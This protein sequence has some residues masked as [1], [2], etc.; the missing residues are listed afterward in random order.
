MTD[1]TDVN[2]LQ[3]IRCSAATCKGQLGLT[4]LQTD[5]LEMG[6]CDVENNNHLAL[7]NVKKD[8]YY[9]VQIIDKSNRQSDVSV[10]FCGS[11]YIGIDDATKCTEKF[12]TIDKDGDG[13]NFY[14]DCNDEDPNINY[15]QAEIP[16]NDIDENCDGIAKYACHKL[17]DFDDDFASLTTTKVI[18]SKSD[19]T[20]KNTRWGADKIS[21]SCDGG[22]LLFQSYVTVQKIKIVKGGSFYFKMKLNDPSE[23][24]VFALYKSS[25]NF[26]KSKLQMIRCVMTGLWTSAHADV[27]GLSPIEAD[28][29]ESGYEDG[30]YQNGFVKSVD[31]NDGDEY[32]IYTNS[33]RPHLTITTSYCGT[34]TFGLDD[35]ECSEIY[36]SDEAVEF[37]NDI[38]IMPNPAHDKIMFKSDLN[39][40]RIEILTGNG[41][42]LNTNRE[43]DIL[44]IYELSSGIYSLLFH[45][46]NGTFVKKFVKY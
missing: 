32:V 15:A 6:G 45:T 37:N 33:F 19:L 34:A 44:N 46:K 8:E 3:L 18:C 2:T 40:Q 20:Y 11:A 21:V 13:Y 30:S 14:S 42:K 31:A 23:D 17:E 38:I 26:E 29:E 1:P 28:L 39:I 4:E 9:A 12:F 27:I 16:F 36:V 35:A 24:L 25:N 7:I 41:I 22:G 43:N 10:Q 5:S